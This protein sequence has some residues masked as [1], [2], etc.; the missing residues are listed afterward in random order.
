[1][2]PWGDPA[3]FGARAVSNIGL[4]GATAG[5]VVLALIPARLGVVGY[6]VPI[7]VLTAGYA[8]FQTANNTAVRSAGPPDQRG[9]VS[10]M[11]NLSR[12]LG[13]ITGASLLGSVFAHAAGAAEVA[14]ADSAAVARGMR[15]TF[16][17]AAMSIAVALVA[18]LVRG[19][20]AS[21]DS[22]A[23]RLLSTGGYQFRRISGPRTSAD[24]IPTPPPS[25]GKIERPCR[26]KRIP[27]RPQSSQTL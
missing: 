1:M 26:T 19:A 8:V 16:A 24:V 6:V 17:V 9:V 21:G 12:N 10:G 5:A 14:A 13:L 11:L 4:F 15:I 27:A 3:E 23:R 25:Y 2:R 7:A 18:R 22:A 20:L